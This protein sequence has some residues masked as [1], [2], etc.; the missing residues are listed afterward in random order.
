MR[1]GDVE[2]MLAN[3]HP[4]V[5]I[6]RLPHTVANGKTEA[7]AFLEEYVALQPEIVE[8]ISI[9]QSDDIIL[10]HSTISI[11]G[12]EMD[13]VG[14]WVLRDGLIWRQTAVIAPAGAAAK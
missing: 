4:D 11:G 6:M 9:D 14:T 3:Y 5:R 2:G 12:D 1:S 7:R 13:L 8:V 10:Y